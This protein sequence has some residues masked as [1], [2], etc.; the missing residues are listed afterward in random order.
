MMWVI[1]E[2]GVVDILTEK[3]PQ[4]VLS[5]K[6]EEAEEEAEKGNS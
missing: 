2:D 4:Q 6:I 3:V 5:Q 1:W